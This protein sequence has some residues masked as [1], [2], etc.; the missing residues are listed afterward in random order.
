MELSDLEEGTSL[1]LTE[2]KDS[3][4]PGPESFDKSGNYL[5]YDRGGDYVLSVALLGGLLESRELR[6]Q[7]S[8]S[9]AV[10]QNSLVGR[11][12]IF[13]T[14]HH[15]IGLYRP[16]VSGATGRL[17]NYDRRNN[18]DYSVGQLSG[19]GSRVTW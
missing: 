3:T 1:A 10:N 14:Y 9:A 5:A 2:I 18:S 6:C 4:K 13:S 15:D 11:I 16:Y 19:C 12:A 8:A 7:V 17:G